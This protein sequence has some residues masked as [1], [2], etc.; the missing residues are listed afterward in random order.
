MITRQPPGTNQPVMTMKKRIAR[1]FLAF[2]MTWIPA[3][4]LAMAGSK[5]AK[6]NVGSDDLFAQSRIFRIQ[7]EIPAAAQLSLK[8]DP[9]NYVKATVRE[10]DR[11]FGEVALRLKGNG[12]FQGLERK[13]SLALKFNEFAPG[14]K[15]HGH[16]KFFLN[17]SHQDP[18]YLCETISGQICRDAGVPAARTAF[19]RVELNGRDAGLYVIAEAVNRDFLARH[20]KKSKGNLYEGSN[21]DITDKLDKDSGDESAEQEDLK[22]L[23]TAAHEPDPIQRWAKLAPLLDIDRFVTFAALEVLVWHHD[24]YSMDRN[25]YRIYHDPTSGRMVFLPHGMDLLFGKPTAPLW[26]EWKGL[27]AHAVLE[28]SEGKNLYTQHMTKLL[29]SVAPAATIQARVQ[30]VA[31][32]IRPAV[33]AGDDLKKFEIA[34]VKLRE[35]IGQRAAF[36]EGELKKPLQ[37]AQR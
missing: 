15:F 7:V 14:Q 1:L 33:P 37:A 9:R 21:V 24:G 36:L 35:S 18:S 22:A 28:T 30:E 2:L 8:K 32:R 34:V 3:L 20:F 11:V 29:A 16:A 17:N 26:P 13:P 31:D 5:A 4:Q 25:N 6:E 10:G 12:S 27:V 19:A 23:A